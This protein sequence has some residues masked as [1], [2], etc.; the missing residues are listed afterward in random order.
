MLEWWNAGMGVDGGPSLCRRSAVD[1][2]RLRE[3]PVER[4][5]QLVRQADHGTDHERDG[6]QIGADPGQPQE[7]P[8]DDDANQDRLAEAAVA[9]DQAQ[10]RQHELTGPPHQPHQRAFRV[11]GQVEAA[12]VRRE[13]AVNSGR[14][15]RVDAAFQGLGTADGL[16]MPSPPGS[17]TGSGSGYGLAAL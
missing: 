8:R 6:G 10:D 15:H 14:F 13:G 3:E 1:Q 2:E 17:D 16:G 12:D 9:G 7:Q 5:A 4:L 11:C